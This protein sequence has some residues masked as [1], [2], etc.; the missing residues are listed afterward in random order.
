MVSVRRVLI[1]WGAAALLALPALA[2]EPGSAQTVQFKAPTRQVKIWRGE[3]PMPPPPGPNL[4]QN[5]PPLP[6]AEADDDSSQSN[7]GENNSQNGSLANDDSPPCEQCGRTR[8]RCLPYWAHRSY[9]FGEF[10]YLHPTGV[11]MAYAIQQNGVGGP[12]TTPE[13][14][15]GVVDPVFTPAFRVGLGVALDRCSSIGGSFTN[16]HSHA[17]DEI[18]ANQNLGSNVSSLLLHPNSVNAGSTSTLIDAAYDI[19]YKLVDLDYRRLLS[20][21]NQHALNYDLGARYA[22]LKQ[23]FQQ[24]GDFTPPAG[25]IQVN[26]NIGFD[27]VGMKTGFDGSHRIGCSRLSFY[28]KGF[29]SVLFGEFTSNYVQVNNTT[30]SV[31]ATSNWTDE[32]VVPILEYELGFNWTSASGHWVMS[33]GYY[34]AF[35]FNTITT[36]QYVQAVQSANFVHLGQTLSFDGLVSRLEYRF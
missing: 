34:T 5:G 15:V 6:S 35:W 9:V 7:W 2:E 27:G 18:V 33:T 32:R 3:P 16:F 36:A 23:Q 17:A 1:A 26:T 25:N 10:L 29:I 28:G 21:S 8:C 4:V 13:G 11:D 31:Q 14:R 22:N 30:T 19:D 20:G 24:I 12:G